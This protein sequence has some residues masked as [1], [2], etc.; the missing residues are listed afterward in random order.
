MRAAVKIDG[1][2]EVRRDRDRGWTAEIA[3]PLG[4]VR[5]RDDRMAVRLPPAVGDSWRINLV[6]VDKPRDRPLTA[7]SWNPITIGDF[8]ALGRMLTAVFASEDGEIAGPGPTS[9]AR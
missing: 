6:R 1:T 8:H 9:S 2:V 7:A 4:A 3:L 5:G